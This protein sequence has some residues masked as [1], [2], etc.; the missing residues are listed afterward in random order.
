[1]ENVFFSFNQKGGE[2][3]EALHVFFSWLSFKETIQFVSQFKKL[4]SWSGE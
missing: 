2:K 4:N 3:D 1:M